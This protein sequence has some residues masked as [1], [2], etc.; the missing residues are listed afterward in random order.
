MLIKGL[1]ERDD[2]HL[3][4]IAICSQIFT[5]ETWFV[6]FKDSFDAKKLYGQDAI[7][8]GRIITMYDS[9]ETNPTVKYRVSWIPHNVNISKSIRSK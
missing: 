2:F 1:C 4:H 5:N 9:N 6:T 8:N 7:I 3:D